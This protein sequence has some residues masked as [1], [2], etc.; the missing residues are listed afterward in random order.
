MLLCQIMVGGII[1]INV[2]DNGRWSK[3][4][5]HIV[6]VLICI[7]IAGFGLPWG[8]LGWLVPIEIFPLEIRS[9]G[10]SLAAA[11]NYLFIFIIAETFIEKVC[12]LN[13][14]AFFF[15]GWW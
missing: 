8:L 6:A 10:Q 7:Y 11:L 15:F 12:T 5:A 13:S 3:A 14:E 2:D 9:V 1:A 4:Y